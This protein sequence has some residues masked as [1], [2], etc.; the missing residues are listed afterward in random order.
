MNLKQVLLL[1]S[2]RV[3]LIP[4]I[5]AHGPYPMSMC[6]MSL[7]LGGGFDSVVLRCDELIVDTAPQSVMGLTSGETVWDLNETSGIYL[8]TF[9]TLDV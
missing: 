2:S 7:Y 8:M 6:H 4:P 9:S 5:A 3:Y 1:T